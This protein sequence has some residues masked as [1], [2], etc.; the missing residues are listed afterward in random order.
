MV[1][2]SRRNLS[3][4]NFI[5]NAYFIL[6]DLS[7]AST[8]ATTR[9][10]AVM[11]IPLLQISRRNLSVNCRL[12]VYYI[13][14]DLSNASTVATTRVLAVMC[15]SNRCQTRSSTRSAKNASGKTPLPPQHRH[16]RCQRS[17]RRRSRTTLLPSSSSSSDQWR[18]L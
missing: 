11:C 16:R 2:F 9:V 18:H 10:L 14:P 13:L 1:K 7:N 17:L 5:L 8:V 15:I 12:N 6:P 4:M 3:M